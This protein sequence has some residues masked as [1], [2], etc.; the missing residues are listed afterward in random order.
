MSLEKSHYHQRQVQWAKKHNTKDFVYITCIA[1]LGICRCLVG[2][3][4]TDIAIMQQLPITHFIK[5]Q[6]QHVLEKNTDTSIFCPVG[7]FAT[8]ETP[9]KSVQTPSTISDEYCT[10][11][12]D[13]LSRTSSLRIKSSGRKICERALPLAYDDISR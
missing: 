7:N 3:T 10:L 4:V 9:S 12:S 5:H 11:R 8:G 2:N 1:D 13:T 6:Q